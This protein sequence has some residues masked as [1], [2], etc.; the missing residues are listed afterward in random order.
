MDPTEAAR[1]CGQAARTL[2]EALGRE[3]D[4]DARARPWHSEQ[5]A[6]LAWQG[7]DDPTEAAGTA[8]RTVARTIHA[9]VRHGPGMHSP[10]A[11]RRLMESLDPSA[12]ESWHRTLSRCRRTGGDADSVAARIR[13]ARPSEDGLAESL[14]P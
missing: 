9:H 10:T 5:D 13:R 8:R 7:Q 4:A 2:A 14:V 11:A 12:D 6:S 1:I 3:T